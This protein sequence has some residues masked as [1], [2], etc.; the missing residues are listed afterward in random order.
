MMITSMRD[1]T[2]TIGVS[3]AIVL[4]FLFFVPV[5]PLTIQVPATCLR[6]YHYYN[7]LSNCYTFYS[8]YG[9]ASY[10]VSGVGMT[11][12]TNNFPPVLSN[13]TLPHIAIGFRWSP[14][15]PR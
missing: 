11:Y 15:L 10:Y 14:N 8:Y 2:L 13:S 5:I 6:G 1:R 4:A 12:L 7:E 3:V 9:S